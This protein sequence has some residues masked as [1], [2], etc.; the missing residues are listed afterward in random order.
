MRDYLAIQSS[1]INQKVQGMCK[2]LPEATHRLM[3]VKGGECLDKVSRFN[4]IFFFYFRCDT[5][6]P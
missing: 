2:T 1:A 3:T 5:E 6:K 4:L